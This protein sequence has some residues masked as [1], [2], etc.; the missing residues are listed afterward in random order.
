MDCALAQGKK[1]KVTPNCSLVTLIICGLKRLLNMS[2]NNRLIFLSPVVINKKMPLSSWGIGQGLKLCVTYRKGGWGT[3]CNL[4]WAQINKAII[5]TCQHLFITGFVFLNIV[6]FL[7]LIYRK[8][9]P[10][11]D[12][13]A[14]FLCIKEPLEYLYQQKPDFPLI[15]RKQ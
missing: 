15:A 3:E 2:I 14:I 12:P 4:C 11:I 6:A 1:E 13:V 5:E 7:M 10:D 9:P 8:W